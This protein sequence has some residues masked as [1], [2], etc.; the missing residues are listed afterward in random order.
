[1]YI[2]SPTS[3]SLLDEVAPVRC[4]RVSG[5]SVSLEQLAKAG[6]AGFDS[7][8]YFTG[9]T[10]AF[11]TLVRELLHSQGL[12]NP[13]LRRDPHHRTSIAKM[14]GIGAHLPT[15]GFPSRLH[16]RRKHDPP[17]PTASSILAL[18]LFPVIRTLPGVLASRPGDQGASA[19]TPLRGGMERDQR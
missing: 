11:A 1:M 2:P 10:G 15:L 12:S 9:F 13:D 6:L 7:P 19:T 4:L 3:P 8:N 5:P 16:L 14:R 17:V 18:R